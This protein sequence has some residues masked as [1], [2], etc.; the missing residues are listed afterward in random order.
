MK[1]YFLLSVC[2][3]WTINILA[4]EAQTQDSIKKYIANKSIAFTSEYGIIGNGITFDKIYPLSKKEKIA[5]SQSLLTSVA[6]PITQYGAIPFY[7]STSL[8]FVNGYLR[9]TE[10]GGY[11]SYGAIIDGYTN[12][13]ADIGLLIGYRYQNPNGGLF[14]KTG[15]K[16]GA[17]SALAFLFAYESYYDSYN[18][19]NLADVAMLP[20][21]IS[22]TISIGKTYKKKNIEYPETYQNKLMQQIELE[23]DN[24]NIK[25]EKFFNKKLVFTPYLQY[26][27]MLFA[28]RAIPKNVY[29][30]D[31]PLDSTYKIYSEQNLYEAYSSMIGLGFSIM[32]KWKYKIS[33]SI[34][35]DKTI[36]NNSGGG[37]GIKDYRSNLVSSSCISILPISFFN[38][39]KNKPLFKIIIPEWGLRYT[40][41]EVKISDLY[42]G[43]PRFSYTSDYNCVQN[44]IQSFAALTIMP[45]YKFNII[46]E[47]PINLLAF[48]NGNVFRTYSLYER[49]PVIV[50]KNIN[51]TE[52]LNNTFGPKELYLNKALLHSLNLKIGYSF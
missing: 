13:F 40:Y 39:I 36:S 42:I 11:I 17:I 14:L 10:L 7:G 46:L 49:Y 18:Q 32:Y 12:P 52:S 50:Y 38:T 20:L 5:F 1:K 43:N 34:K 35:Y 3:T 2:I 4:Q 25:R 9:A 45:F 47:T 22:P 16:L 28:G 19:S 24:R 51:W 26:D 30:Q 48:T 21:I 44:Y 8:S 6:F 37:L 29:R 27:N 15:V 41:S 23:S 31:S 33:T